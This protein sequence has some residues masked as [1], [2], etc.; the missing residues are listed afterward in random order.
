MDDHQ[1]Q[2][3]VAKEEHINM[4]AYQYTPISP[5]DEIRCLTLEPGQ[6]D[7]PLLGSIKTYNFAERPEYEAISYAWGVPLF[8]SILVCD[9]RQ[10]PITRTLRDSLRQCRLPNEL[11]VLW[12]DSICID[13]DNKIEKSHQVRLMADI[14]SQAKQVLICLG[15]DNDGHAERAF[16]FIRDVNIM[17]ED[18]LR[19]CESWD[20]FPNLPLT[21]SLLHDTR[22]ESFRAFTKHPWFYRGWVIQEATLA[23][24]AEVFYG[25]LKCD[26][27]HILRIF[28]WKVKRIGSA[29]EKYNPNSLDLHLD[30]YM[31]RL[32]SEA[33]YFFPENAFGQFSLAEILNSAKV[34]SFTDPRD[35]IYAFLGLPMAQ[36]YRNKLD[37]SYE[38]TVLET[39]RSFAYFCIEK[40]RDLELLHFVEHEENTLSSEF[41]SWVPQWQTNVYQMALTRSWY[42]PIFPERMPITISSV[43]TR[44][45]GLG[46][47]H[48]KGIIIDKVAFAS[49]RLNESC[50]VADVAKVWVKIQIYERRH[51]LSA[52]SK[53]PPASAFLEAITCGRSRAHSNHEEPNS[54]ESIYLRHLEGQL[55]ANHGPRYPTAANSANLTES[56]RLQLTHSMVLDHIHNRKIAITQRGFYGLLPGVAE[57]D[58]LCCILYG[59]KTPFVLRKSAVTGL[60]QLLGDASIVSNVGGSA[61]PIRI[62]AG[63]RFHPELLDLGLEEQ[64]FAIV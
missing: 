12:A 21:H 3:R 55:P 15:P 28:T 56:E 14:Y 53:Y 9:G 62:G 36:N 34:L 22:W 49:D 6:D 16:S 5:G 42:A 57:E 26:W 59:T 58:D 35:R 44:T 27:L 60:Y 52:H 10:I 11:R 41:P 18:N 20:S 17:V 61:A 37:I 47:L 63:N 48:L 8:Q 29:F 13:Q 39:Y 38:T 32:E 2:I 51:G 40:A 45:D 4:E 54:I 30:S 64:D 50:S 1:S 25:R 31:S 7:D 23:T 19:I 46:S 24:R 33:I 43:G